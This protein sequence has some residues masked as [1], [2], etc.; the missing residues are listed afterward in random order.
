MWLPIWINRSDLW[1]AFIA[2]TVLMMAGTFTV[3]DHLPTWA[4]PWL[5][6]PIFWIF[7]G[8][9]RALRGR[10]E[11]NPQGPQNA[12]SDELGKGS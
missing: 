6:I 10:T 8:L 9:F 7:V 3:S 4:W 2:T 5:L 11:N 12:A 1:R